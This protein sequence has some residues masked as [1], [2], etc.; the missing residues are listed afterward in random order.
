M[1]NGGRDRGARSQ[2]DPDS[3]RS[4]QAIAGRSTDPAVRLA[5][6]LLLPVGA[7]QRALDA[8]PLVGDFDWRNAMSNAKLFTRDIQPGVFV[9]RGWEA[10]MVTKVVDGVA[11]YCKFCAETG[12]P[13]GQPFGSCTLKTFLTWAERLASPDEVAGYDRELI[14]ESSN[15][16]AKRWLDGMLALVPSELLSAELESRGI[17]PAK[18]P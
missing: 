17:L 3:L 6:V 2:G 7:G 16:A 14:I 13:Y 8:N 9:I 11:T 5:D 15:Q 12:D 4:T 1:E 10:R 18:T